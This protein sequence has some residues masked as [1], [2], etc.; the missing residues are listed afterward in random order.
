MNLRIHA[1]AGRSATT[2]VEN[3]LPQHTAFVHDRCQ[4]L[5]RAGRTAGRAADE[6]QSQHAGN[7][8]WTSY[9]L[10]GWERNSKPI[11]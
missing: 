9:A 5:T 4:L 7:I 2:H 3:L 10:R 8:S 11:A 1:P 6:P